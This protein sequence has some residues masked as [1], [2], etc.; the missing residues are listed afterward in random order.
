MRAV[1]WVCGLLA[2]LSI[3]CSSFAGTVYDSGGFEPQ[4][5]SPGAL[6][7]QDGGL[8]MDSGSGA[9]AVVQTT[10]VA[11]GTQAVQVDRNDGD[12]RFFPIL[13]TTPAV[14]RFV[15]IN[16]DMNVSQTKLNNV[17][18]GPFFGIEA[19]TPATTILGAAGVDA[20]TG[21]LLYE[22]PETGILTETGTKVPFGKFN[23]YQLVIDNSAK[24][25]SIYF[26]NKLI[27]KTSGFVDPGSTGFSDADISALAADLE[28]PTE[29]GTAFFDNYSVTTSNTGPGGR[30][31]PLPP[32]VWPGLMTLGLGML[33]VRLRQVRRA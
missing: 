20:T 3:V 19:Y 2:G 10:T 7:G 9:S 13:P 27:K 26:N 30:T 16:W 12:M 6:T 31:I 28:P 33:L 25:F 5:F 29:K 23:H 14:Q 18:F 22:A 4:R 8:W 1:P 11:S 17:V 24:N 32:A 21:D 15:F